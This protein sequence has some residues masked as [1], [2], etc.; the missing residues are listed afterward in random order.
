MEFWASPTHPFCTRILSAVMVRTVLMRGKEMRV[1]FLA[2]T[3]MSAGCLDPGRVHRSVEPAIRCD[4]RRNGGPRH[5]KL[6]WRSASAV[7]VRRSGNYDPPHHH[8][9]GRPARPPLSSRHQCRLSRPGRAD[10]RDGCRSTAVAPRRRRPDRSRQH[11]AFRDK[12][13]KRS[14]RNHRLLCGHYGNAVNRQSGTLNPLPRRHCPL[15]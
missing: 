2:L 12:R 5:P 15:A 3:L 10:G 8:S 1:V 7:S 14:G 9:T 6:E 13:R 4:S 11:V